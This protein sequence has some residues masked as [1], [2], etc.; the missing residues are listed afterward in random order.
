MN[1]N[2]FYIY[3]ANKSNNGCASC[4]E[5]S[6]KEGREVM[7]FWTVARQNSELN[8]NGDATFAWGDRSE[9]VCVKL[10]AVDLGQLLALLYGYQNDVGGGK[11]LYHQNN[12]GSTVFNFSK[13]GIRVSRKDKED[14]E[15]L[16]LNH[17]LAPS[18]LAILKVVLEEMIRVFFTDTFRKKKPEGVQLVDNEVKP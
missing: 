13:T 10:G 11:G 5:L 2:K 15:A 14:K 18:D 4:L 8:A 16:I 7:G 9:T 1:N 12:H 17:A 3:R 6:V